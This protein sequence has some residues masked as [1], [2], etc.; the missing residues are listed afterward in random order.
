MKSNVYFTNLR[1]KLGTNLLQKLEKLIIKAGILDID[2]KNKF[3]CIKIHFGEPGNLAYIRPNY[4]KVLVDLIKKQGG[5]PFVSDTN[6]LYVGRRKNAVEH[7]EA[8]YENGFNPFQIGCPVIIGDG[9]KGNS[10]VEVPINLKYVQNAKIGKEI[11]EADII[12]TMSHFKGHESAGFGGCVKN[13]GMG[14]GSRRGKMEMHNNGKPF[15]SPNICKKCLKCLKICAFNAISMQEESA[16]I[17]DSKCVGC[18]RCIGV[19]NYDAIKCRWD[20]SNEILNEKIAEYAYAAVLNKPSFH[21]NFIMNVSPTC[22]CVSSNDVAVIPDQGILA[23][24]DPVAID[25]ASSN[26]C[27]QA[28]RYQDSI[29]KECKEHNHEENDDL[30][31]FIHPQTNWKMQMNHGEEI[32][33]GVKDYRLI[34]VN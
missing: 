16:N 34:K 17:D 20:E 21:I 32:K 13:L 4:V 25:Q 33:L 8:A 9:L 19:C 23:S 15:V 7:I 14:C 30:F 26:I 12:I 3:V 1:C 24:F 11:H 6:T 22:D 28:T 10:D 27:N 2:F 29:I 18:G 31:T 5:I